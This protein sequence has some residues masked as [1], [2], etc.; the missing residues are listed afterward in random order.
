MGSEA[1]SS[2]VLFIAALAAAAIAGGAMAGVIGE[3]TLEFRER[4][5]GLTDAIG[6]DLAIINDPKNVP[7]DDGAN[8]LT[9]YV[10]N[11][12]SRALT[13]EELT[14]LVDGVD[15]DFNATLIQDGERWSTGT[16]QDLTVDV[17]L[18]GGDHRVRAVYT[19]N[20]G[21]TLDFR[22]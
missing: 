11:T 10:K 6:T 4:G 8:E 21:D 3:M 5:S 15:E 9:V 22:I 7:Y 16:V 20:V 18:D 2:M 14:I 12:G 19:P 1:S 13:T 17:D